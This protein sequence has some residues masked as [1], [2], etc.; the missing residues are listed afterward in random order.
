MFPFLT[1]LVLL[2]LAGA[3]LLRALPEGAR[4]RVREIALG[5]T[6]LE[7]ALGIVM[8]TQFD[9]SDAATQQFTETYSWIPQIGASWALG[10]NGFGLSMVALSLILTPLVILAEWR[11]DAEDHHRAARYLALI[12]VLQAFMVGIFAARDVFLFYVMFEAML[13]PLYFLIGGFGGEQRRYAAVK[14]LLYSLV[15]GLIMLVAVVALYFVG[16]GGEQAYLIDNLAGYDFGTTAERLMFLGFFLAFAIKAPMVPVHTWLPTVAETAR[17]GTTA[18]LVAVLDKIGTFGMITLGMVIFPQASKWAAPVIIVFAVISVI[19]GAVAAIGQT[20][21]LRL[22][23]FTSVSHFGIMVLGIYAFQQTSVEGAA[24]YM[25]N[26]GLSTGALFLVVGFLIERNGSPHVSAYG[27]LQKVVPV[28]AGTF[29]VIGLS[30]L[31]LPGL[32]PFVSEIM[33]LVGSFGVAKAAVVVAALGV[34]LAAL[35][36][37]LTYQ[38]VFTGP[39]K[40]GLEKTRELGIRERF[41][42]WPLIGLMLLLGFLPSLAI[43]YLR[44]PAAAV[45]T[46]VNAEVSE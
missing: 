27:G 33:V 4:S 3:A 44:D 34:I 30:A 7:L 41:V 32:S 15:G 25:F 40:E 8:L 10:V 37:L 43:D 17:P 9:L 45:V 42:L 6:L 46:T 22:V 20:D 11:R 35:Y 5:V 39:T 19:Y 26:H 38:K 29:L 28:M 36:V 21:M 23:S 16:P 18:L 24:F 13:I 12:L 14:F 1:V 31:A 2:P